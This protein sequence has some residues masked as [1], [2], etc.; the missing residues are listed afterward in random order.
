MR[1]SGCYK[2]FGGPGALCFQRTALQRQDHVPAQ[3]PREAGAGRLGTVRGRM[4]WGARESAQASVREAG[5]PWSPN[6]CGRQLTHLRLPPLSGVVWGFRPRWEE[7]QDSGKRR[8]QTGSRGAGA[9]HRPQTRPWQGR[10][11]HSAPSG[12]LRTSLRPRN[13][14]GP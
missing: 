12:S 3:W 10:V 5:R 1:S 9:R 7:T 13:F 2:K 14:G 8:D 4:P 6:S 11:T